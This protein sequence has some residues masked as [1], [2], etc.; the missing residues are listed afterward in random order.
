MRVSGAACVCSAA[1]GSARG[2][3]T[4]LGQ[5]A[6]PMLEGTEEGIR[7]DEAT[8]RNAR[9]VEYG[10][11]LFFLN[12][13]DTYPCTASSIYTYIKAQGFRAPPALPRHGNCSHEQ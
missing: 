11:R 4:K 10:T 3:Q 7:R 9:R 2:C 12:S 8:K 5:G 1:G 6:R 13:R